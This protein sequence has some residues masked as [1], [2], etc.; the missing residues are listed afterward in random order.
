MPSIRP[1]LGILVSWDMSGLAIAR[2]SIQ[3]C[4][5]GC[6]DKDGLCSKLGAPGLPASLVLGGMTTV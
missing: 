2:F 4:L 5:Q 3:G 6:V 1:L